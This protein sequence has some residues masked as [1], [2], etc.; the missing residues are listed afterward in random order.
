MLAQKSGR[1]SV[2][3]RLGWARSKVSET[4]TFLGVGYSYDAKPWTYGVA[5]GH[6]FLSDDNI[7]PAKDDTQHVELFVKRALGKNTTLT[8]SLQSLHN[9]QF[10]T[11]D[12]T[13]DS[14]VSVLSLRLQHSF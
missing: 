10:D 7:D 8:A 9:S 1:H 12:V 6:Y 2:E 3:A 5:Y 11:S 14:D 4:G 13:R